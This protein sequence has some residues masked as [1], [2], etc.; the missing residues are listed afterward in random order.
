MLAK[1][2]LG[3]DYFAVNSVLPLESI[4]LLNV[5]MSVNKCI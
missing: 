1:S 2:K 5:C 3:S 4:L